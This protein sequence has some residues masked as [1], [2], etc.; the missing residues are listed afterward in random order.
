MRRE[1]R[2]FFF[3]D[4]P[5]KK[6]PLHGSCEAFRVSFYF[7]C[8]YVCVSVYI[9]QHRN[10]PLRSTALNVYGTNASPDGLYTR[11]HTNESF[12]CWFCCKSFRVDR[13]RRGNVFFEAWLGRVAWNIRT[14]Y[15]Y[16][17][18]TPYLVTAFFLSGKISA[19]RGLSQLYR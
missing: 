12:S 8:K 9:I 10:R 19:E 7:L 4:F 18:D 13:A 3:L 2:S 1:A 6:K 15:K 17:H 11:T 14:R 16:Q 5:R